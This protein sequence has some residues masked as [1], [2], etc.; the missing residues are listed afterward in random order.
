MF[1]GYEK[2]L[3]FAPINKK[4]KNMLHT[5]ITRISSLLVVNVVVETSRA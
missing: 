2:Q 3:T 1:A 4:E 5:V